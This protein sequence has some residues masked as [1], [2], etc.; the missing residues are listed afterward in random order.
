MV[1]IARAP[2]ARLGSPPTPT[3]DDAQRP[4]PL[5]A[6]PDWRFACMRES[7][8]TN[9]SFPASGRAQTVAAVMVIALAAL[10]A[11]SD[12]LR[13]PFVFD[14]G[15]ATLDN[16]SIRTL[17]SVWGALSP[18]AGT[19]VAGRPIANLTLAVNFALSGTNVWSYHA[20][21]L[22]VHILGGVTLFGI[23][24]RT[25]RRPAL[26][27][28]FARDA[29]PLALAAALL[30]TLHP[31]QT[32][33][34]TY[35]VQRVESL[36][37]LFYL[38][39]LYCFLRSVESTRP[40]RWQV[41]AV[42]ACLLGM[43]TKE[44]VVTAPLLVLLYDRAFVAGT[45]R[46][47]W[48]QRRGLY[49]GLAATWLPL[50]FLMASAGWSRGGSAGF[51]GNIP[52]GA[53]WLTQFEAVTRYLRLSVWPHPLVF[54]YGT[55]LVQ[56]PGDAAPYALFVFAL[57]ALALVALWRW[58]A[59][60]FLGA[61]Y[62][63]ILAPT[64]IVPVATQTMAEHRMYLPLA[65]VACLAAAGAYAFAGRRCL[66]PLG[67]LALVLGF[68]TFERNETYRSGLTLWADTVAKR[69]ENARAH[70]SLGL[71][72][73]GIPGKLPQAISEYEAAIRIHPDYSD[74]H[75]DLGIAL[76]NTPGRLGDAIGQFGEALRIRPEFAQA[77]NNLGMAL[78]Q[79]DRA[80]EAMQEY[81]AALRI[82]PDY[83]EAH[84]NLGLLLCRAGRSD[85]GIL[86]LEAALRIN[87]DYAPAHFY[88]ANALVQSGRVPEA[89]RHY[90]DALRA[91]PDFAEASNNYGMVL[92][93]IGR[94]KEGIEHIEAAIRMQPDF[95]QAHFARGVALLQTGRRDE[96]I[97][98]Y[99]RVLQLRPNDPSA[100]RMLELIRTAH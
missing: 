81:E 52:P 78:A 34:V 53:Y 35:V 21:N 17:W 25:L 43:G 59:L 57:A 7:A 85:E 19:T 39:T 62:F 89:I 70:C 77:H 92:C 28:R 29:F 68:L 26:G 6:E 67:A 16:A 63:A 84:G 99:E 98:E 18:P 38:L 1:L 75:N 69:P 58:P 74:A 10:A 9:D 55:F 48:R 42:A 72:L 97:A 40:L 61:W 32:E 36:A 8:A 76:E 66:A 11:Y 80:Q 65:A 14:D 5:L 2:G 50:T 27:G 31:L 37:G 33:A 56:G 100:L 3:D 13:A 4:D 71:I 96:A 93:R 46:M 88:L 45:F 83:F 24:R 86:Q 12:S 51:T 91:Q 60:G 95:V 30:W 90:E 64:S 94:T 44:V 49:V 54:D 22:L 41:C 73:S 20:L 82:K 23:L 79:T 87:P 47:A 15:P